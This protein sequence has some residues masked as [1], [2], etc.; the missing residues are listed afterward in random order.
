MIPFLK[1]NRLIIFVFCVFFGLYWLQSLFTIT[2]EATP[3][4]NIPNYSV[5]TLYPWADPKTIDEQVTDKIAKKLKTISLVKKITSSSSYNVSSIMVE[6]YTEKKDVD[7]ISDIKSA[8]DQTTSSLPSDVKTPLVKKVDITWLPIYQFAIS[9]PYSSETL[10]KKVENL[11]E[12]IKSIPWVSDI[13]ISG[14]P[15]HE[16]KVN[17]DLSKILS[18]DLDFGNVITQL[19][20]MFLKIPTDKKNIKWSLYS[21]EVDTYIPQLTGLI[22][23]IKDTNI[24]SNWWKTIKVSDIATVY[25]SYRDNP[26]KLFIVS[27]DETINA[28]WFAVSR[29]P[30]FD[31]QAITLAM[32]DKVTEFHK[33][34]PD[35]Q[36]L[37]IQSSEQIINKTYSLFLENFW[38]TGLFV[39]LVVVVFLWRRSSILVLFAFL[40]VYLI[41][42]MFLKT[43]GYTFN[44]IVSFSLILVLGIM[45]DNLIV[46]TQWITIWLRE[47]KWNIWWAIEYALENYWSAVFFWTLCTI[48]IFLP[49]LFGLTWVVGEYMKSFPVVI[50]SNLTIS[51]VISLIWL[52]I[53]FT[54]LNKKSKN[55]VEDI[56]HSDK[57]FDVPPALH[58]L[59]R[60]GEWFGSLFY[61][62]NKTRK[63]SW[64]VIV[65][66]WLVF[67]WSIA[68]IALGFIKTDFLGDA[69]NDNIW[70]NMKYRPGISAEENQ[71]NTQKVLKDVV[72]YTDEHYKNMIDYISVEIWK[73]NGVQWGWWDTSHYSSITLKLHPMPTKGIL[74]VL[75]INKLFGSKDEKVRTI[76]SYTMVEQIREYI[77]SD[78]KPK[79]SF[80]QEIAP[81]QLKW[82]PSWW[83]PI[84]FY[85][86][87][88]DLET[89]WS[90]MATIMPDLQ[91]TKWLF[92]ISSNIQY[93]NWRIVYTLDTNKLK[94]YNVSALSVINILAG[95]KNSA[96]T[97]NGILIKEFS[98]FGKDTIKLQWYVLYTWDISA[99]KI[100]QMPL[101]NV[102][103]SI[104]LQPEL[105]SIDRNDN[106]KA[107]KIEA[108]KQR[109]TA[110]SDITANIETIIKNHPLPEWISYKKAGDVESQD[111]SG[112]DLWKSIMIGMILMY[113]VLLLL[114]RN[115]KYPTAIITSIFLSVWWSLLII[116]ITWMT[117]NFP[118]QLGIFWVLWVWVNQAIIHV[119]DFKIFYEKQWMTVLDSFRKS[120]AIRFVPIFLTKLTT[121]LWLIILSFKDEIYGGLAVAFIGWLLMSFFITLLYLPTLIRLA[122]KDTAPK[123]VEIE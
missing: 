119:E 57:E 62:L 81:V 51:L 72:T 90:Y 17:F 80:I 50:D 68:L 100:G 34:N 71:S 60:W 31:I 76:K 86:V 35:I 20:W 9:G 54:Y 74:D 85:L 65:T 115:F 107:I 15:T 87:G 28:I 45:V 26:N 96:Y 113:L 39:F 4:V 67:M 103:K 43:V 114:F 97:P 95:I 64:G 70:I 13:S 59:E 63:R 32:K 66:F 89:L 55:K 106:K 94:D 58:V 104:Q 69:D 91:K 92:N 6:F 102:V 111:S 47:K 99:I 118:A 53:M 78:I 75:W 30:W 16:I 117:F 40:L 14:N 10:Y 12:D 11:E 83:K 108:D 23:Q 33:Q 8:I 7:A 27:G 3:T 120:I 123:V 21:F 38:E 110:L 22:Q 5:I 41:N 121:I 46:I 82:W 77:D 105:L 1:S 93:S 98:D 18:L 61:R 44:N 49:L 48:V 25:D 19:R 2:K 112:K 36:T 79:Y 84:W 37:E 52:P 122:S 56:K 101:D 109:D 116:A 73:Q 88:D 24:V 29:T 42:F